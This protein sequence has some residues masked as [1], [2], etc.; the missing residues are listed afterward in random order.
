MLSTS[1]SLAV[2]AVPEG[3][4]A[5]I[6][7]SLSLG[8]S[9]M[10]KRHAVLD[11]PF[12][13]RRNA[14][15][16]MVI[17][18]DKTGTLTRNEMTAV[19]FALPDHPDVRVSGTGYKAEGAFHIEGDKPVSVGENIFLRRFVKAMALSTNA[20]PQ[21]GECERSTVVLGDTTEAALMVAVQ[22]VAIAANNWSR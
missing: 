16:V 11:P 6:T 18:S 3:L 8:A 7:I 14:R 9:R 10:V 5:L 1:I 21:P 19:R 22:K 17:C 20:D 2:A 12:A 4:P 15:P 13:C